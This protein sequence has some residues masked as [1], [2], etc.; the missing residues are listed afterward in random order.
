MKGATRQMMTEA[1]AIADLQVRA[2]RKHRCHLE[3]WVYGGGEVEYCRGCGESIR[4]E[5]GRIVAFVAAR[6]E[7]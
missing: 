7:G 5:G 3:T 1:A 6:R 2:E 4:L